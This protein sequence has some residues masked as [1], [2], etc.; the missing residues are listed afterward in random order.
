MTDY[1]ETQVDKFTFKVPTDRYY[2][3]FGVWAK[4][5]GNHI[6][7]GLSD[8]LQQ[9]SGDIAFADVRPTGTILAV[10]DEASD[11]ET[12]KVDISIPSPLAGKIVRVNPLMENEAETINMDPYGEG[13]VCEI[14]PSNWESDLINLMDADAY[15]AHMKHQAEEEV[16]KN[17]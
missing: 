10:G 12:I 3:S 13:W 17:E 15:F 2:N 4:A 9:S 16:K 11:I 14:E 6:R 8:Y 7:I 1:L 5:E